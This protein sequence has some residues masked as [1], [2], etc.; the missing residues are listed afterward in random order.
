MD[1]LLLSVVRM[2]R[3]ITPVML[4]Q[5]GGAIT[6]ISSFA[7]LEPSAPRP[8][9]SALRAALASFT[10]LYADQYA[11]SGIRMNSVLPGWVDT[12]GVRAHILEK[13]PMKRAGDPR[14]IA[15]AVAFLV[16]EESSYVTGETLVWTALYSGPCRTR[17]RGSVAAPAE[18]T[19]IYWHAYRKYPGTEAVAG[20]LYRC[21]PCHSPPNATPVSAHRVAPVWSCSSSRQ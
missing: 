3:L 12:Y 2:A 16:S 21:K 19:V 5:G 7:A 18:A 8:V 9:S 17:G 15:R 11:A 4:R 1:L 13:I 20:V 10:K 14:E 6:N